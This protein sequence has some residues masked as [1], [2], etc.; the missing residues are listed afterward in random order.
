[1]KYRQI[2]VLF[3]HMLSIKES[4]KIAVGGQTNPYVIAKFVETFL[5]IMNPITPHF[6][7]HVWQTKVYPVL[8]QQNQVNE[9]L[10][11]N[12]WPQGG[13][14]DRALT[15][16]LKFLENTKRE[17]C[18]A[19]DKAKSGGKRKG[20]N[21]GGAAAEVTLDSCVVAVGK[22]FPEYKLQILEILNAQQWDESGSIQGKDYIAAISKAFP[23]KK[24]KQLAQGYAAFVI[25]EASEVGKEQALVTSSPFDE[26]ELINMNKNY[27]FESVSTVTN[28]EVLLKEDDKLDSIPNGKSIAE[29]AAPG[30]PAMIF[31]SSTGAPAA[32]PQANP[33]GKKGQAPKGGNPKG[34]KG[35]KQQQAQGGGGANNAMASEIESK[36][37]DNLWLGG[38]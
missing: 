2:I 11:N 24:K 35:G 9:I 30:K 21:A 34:G 18:L 1:M 29:A 31:Y 23:D 6:C 36:L 13:P 22:T 12:G 7:Q 4:Y 33:A 14:T 3:N 38:Q 16:Q 37:G 32:T 28:I 17:I 20:K 19:V 25:K 26:V 15:A 10:M 5:T 8:H 27:L